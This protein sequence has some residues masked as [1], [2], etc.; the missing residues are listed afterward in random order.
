MATR[1]HPLPVPRGGDP[2]VAGYP[3]PRGQPYSRLANTY[4]PAH[5]TSAQTA[6]ALDTIGSD[7]LKKRPHANCAQALMHPASINAKHAKRKAKRANTP[8]IAAPTAVEPM[9]PPTPNANTLR[10]STS[11]TTSDSLAPT[12]WTHPH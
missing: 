12:T 2:R 4:L 3:P 5:T 11:S 1:P 7:A 8:S 10:P 6:K 9:R